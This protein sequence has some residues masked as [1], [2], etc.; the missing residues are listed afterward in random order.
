LPNSPEPHIRTLVAVGDSGV[1][2]VLMVFPPRGVRLGGSFSLIDQTRLGRW[3]KR[4][5][6][7]GEI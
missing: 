7:S 2:R 5:W 1:P 3:Q 4:A 6:G